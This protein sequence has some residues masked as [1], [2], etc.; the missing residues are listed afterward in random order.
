LC[1]SGNLIKE[2]SKK[3]SWP[4]E[5]YLVAQ[6]GIDSNETFDKVVGNCPEGFPHAVQI[7]SSVSKSGRLPDWLK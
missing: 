6:S 7:G 5:C 1:N 3:K 4:S 2:F